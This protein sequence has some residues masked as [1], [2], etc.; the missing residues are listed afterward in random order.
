MLKGADYDILDN[1]SPFLVAIIERWFD[2]TEASPVNIVYTR[3][4][5]IAYFIIRRGMRP[6]W[7]DEEI[8]QLEASSYEFKNVYRDGFGKYQP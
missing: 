8:L 3:Y 5:H 4:V 6:W 2:L 7:S 1:F